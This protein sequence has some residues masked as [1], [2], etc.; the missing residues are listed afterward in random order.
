MILNR[1]HLNNKIVF[2][3]LKQKLELSDSKLPQM[4]CQNKIKLTGASFEK[5]ESK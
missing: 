2:V 4:N 5:Q 1:S 3:N